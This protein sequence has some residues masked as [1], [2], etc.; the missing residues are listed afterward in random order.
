MKGIVVKVNGDELMYDSFSIKESFNS[1]VVEVIVNLYQDVF[2]NVVNIQ[3]Q[4]FLKYRAETQSNG[5][6]RTILWPKKFMELMNKQFECIN[7]NATFEEIAKQYGVPLTIPQKSTSTYWCLPQMKFTRF[8]DEIRDR[9]VISGG[10]GIVMTFG[11]NNTLRIVDL[12]KS[13]ES[14]EAISIMGRMKLATDN[15]KWI[16]SVPAMYQVV[17]SSIESDNKEYE[18]KFYNNYGKGVLTHIYFNE[19]SVDTLDQQTTNIF[20]RKLFTSRVFHYDDLQVPQEIYLGCLVEDIT[21][22]QKMIVWETEY[23]GTQDAVILKI[24]GV[25]KP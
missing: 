2:D 17:K 12:K 7:K 10:G 22:N 14:K 25:N 3:G 8:L 6:I 15:L 16:S 21:T 1:L 13:A 11:F 18:L 24:I 5:I 20:Y 23:V 9:I 19:K 4:D